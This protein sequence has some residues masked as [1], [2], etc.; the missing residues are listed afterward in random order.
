MEV[1]VYG[2]SWCEDTQRTLKQLSGFGVAYEYIDIE[3]DTEAACW[4]REQN[5]GKQRTPTLEVGGQILS[6]PDEEELESV[7]REKGFM[8]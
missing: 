4:V 6:V 7:L 2:T 5:G 3:Q 8:A 1:K